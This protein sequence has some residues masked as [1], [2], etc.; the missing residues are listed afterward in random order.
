MLRHIYQLG[1]GE[2]KKLFPTAFL[3][4]FFKDHRHD[5]MKNF[6]VFRFLPCPLAIEHFHFTFL[7]GTLMGKGKI[8]DI[9]EVCDGL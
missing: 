6:N 1:A 8:Q 2:I 3:F 7:A 9:L 5:L 4:H